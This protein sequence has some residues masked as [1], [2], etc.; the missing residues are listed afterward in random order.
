MFQPR[1]QAESADS[2]GGDLSCAQGA[3]KRPGSVSRRRKRPAELAIVLVAL[4]T[5]ACQDAGESRAHLAVGTF[6]G[7]QASQALQREL[8]RISR[9][10]GPVSIEVRTF[11]MAALN[12]YL[13]RPQPLA[14]R[15]SLDLAI[16]PHH[17]LGQL[18]QRDVIEELPSERAQVLRQKLVGQALL[19]VSD[20]DRV[21]GYPISA[22][23]LAL[24]YDPTIFPYP[25]R[26]IDEILSTR[27][28]AGVLPFA[29]DISSPQA[30]VPLVGSL[31]GTLIDADGSLVWRPAVVMET[32]ERLRPVWGSSGG[33]RAFRGSDLESLQVQLYSAGKLASFVAGPWLLQ[34]LEEGGRPFAVMPIP[35]FAGAPA[36]AR[37]LVGYQCIVVSRGSRWGDLALEVGAQLLREDSS[38]RINQATRRLPV[39]LRAYESK[40]GLTSAGSFGFLRALEQGQFVPGTPHWAEEMQKAEQQLEEFASHAQPP[41]RARDA[42]RSAG[43]RP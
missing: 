35:G 3:S 24:V 9:D 36:R 42:A 20:G 19:A 4:L 30:L 10:L 34:A 1:L 22:E 18:A 17:W 37:A 25:P 7:G 39:L 12:D 14:G 38:D 11:G 27:F 21:F 40:Q 29:L 41:A 43:G 28:Q 32:L 2:D 16:V 8:I 26:T 23:V 31:Q 15:E 33:W 13:S 6:W 5:G